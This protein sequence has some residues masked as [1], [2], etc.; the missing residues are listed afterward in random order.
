MAAVALMLAS[1]L[2]LY[3][4]SPV[5]TC[6]ELR[7]TRL[8]AMP[9]EMLVE[10]CTRCLSQQEMTVLQ[11]THEGKTTNRSD[12]GLIREETVAE[13]LTAATGPSFNTS[14]ESDR[15]VVE[16]ARPPYEGSE[17]LFRADK[18]VAWPIPEAVLFLYAAAD[19]SREASRRIAT[20]FILAVPEHRGKTRLYLVTARHVVDPEWARCGETNPSAIAV[21]FNRWDGGVGYE[22]LT[23]ESHGAHQFLTAEDDVTDLA[24]IPLSADTVP[25]LERYKLE[26]TTLTMLPTAVELNAL[27]RE[28]QIV[29]AGVSSPKLA[30]LRDSPIS[31]SGMI[32]SDLSGA[33]VGVRCTAASPVRSIHMW[34]IDTS[35]ERGVSGAPVYAAV[36]RGPNQLMTP[37]LVGVQSVVWPDRGQAGITPV[38]ALRDLAELQRSRPEVAMNLRRGHPE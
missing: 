29:T 31:A 28:E 35:V 30:G 18:P 3:G 11:Q 10:E 22:T 13:S 2:E 15:P 27:R 21:R 19:G 4:C 34:L 5:Q 25:G 9:W 7:A 23:L 17:R 36:A 26:E 37:V 20:G 6:E 12:S 1:F 8:S 32:A 33:S 14:E 38:A 24:L 16:V